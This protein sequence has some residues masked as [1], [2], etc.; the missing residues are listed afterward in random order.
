MW[1]ET[2][3]N[4]LGICRL[5]DM[6]ADEVVPDIIASYIVRTCTAANNS[7]VN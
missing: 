1:H 2:T 6:H 3:Q 4:R 5:K 7:V